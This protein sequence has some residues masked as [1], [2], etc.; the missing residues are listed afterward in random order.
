MDWMMSDVIPALLFIM[1]FSPIGYF[2][3]QRKRH[4]NRIGI[5]ADPRICPG[6]RQMR[7]PAFPLC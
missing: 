4:S 3:A 5:N 6:I 7:S 2:P 1:I